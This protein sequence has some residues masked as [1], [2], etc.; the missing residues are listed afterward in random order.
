MAISSTQYIDLLFKSLSGVAKTDLPTN[1]SASNEAIASPILNRGDQ[2]WTESGLIPST[3]AAVS[4]VVQAYTGSSKATAT[5]DSTAQAVGGV[6]PTWRTNLTNWVPPQF[7]TANIT[8]TYRVRIFYGASGLSDPATSGG[9]QI[10]AD[11][12]SGTGEWYFDYASGVLNFIGGTIPAGMTGSSV[13]YVYGYRY[14]GKVGVNNLPAITASGT[15]TFSAINALSGAFTATTVS[16]STTTGALVVN[17]G[18]GIG[19]STF[20]GGNLTVSGTI[21]ATINGVITT[22]TNIAGGTAGQ[23]V[24]Q[25]AP[26]TTTFAGPG[27]AG[28]LLVSN[29]TSGPQYTNTGSIYVGNTVNAEKWLTARTVTFTGD[30]TGT[31]TIDGSADVTSVNLTIQPNS[32]ALGT[33]TTGDYVATGATSGFGLSGSTTGE[34]QTFTVTSNATS[35]NANS[36]I[37]FR[38][39]SGNFSAGTITA[40]TFSGTLGTGGSQSINTNAL[41][42]SNYADN[43]GILYFSNGSGLIASNSASFAW[44]NTAGTLRVKTNTTASSTTTGALVVTGGVG[45]GGQLF[46]GSTA[47]IT[48]TAASTGSVANNALQV[49]GGVGI[50]GSLYVKGPAIFQNDVVFAGTSTYVYSTQTI[51]TD[52]LINM[53]VPSGSTGTDHTW[54]VDDGKDVGF[55][56]HYYKNTD[57]D[58]FLGFNNTS[59]YLEWFNDGNENITNGTFTGTSYGVFKTGGIILTNSTASS[60]PTTGALTVAGGVGIGGN[61]F[62]GGSINGTI[63]TATNLAGGTAGQTPYQTAAG[64]TSFYG[65]GTAGQLLVS[66]GTSGP[67]Y[68]NTGSIYVGNTVNAEKW[69]TARTV[70][71]TGDTTGTFTIDGSANVTNVNLTIQPD[72]VSLGTDTTGNYVATGAT[73]GFGLSGSASSEGGTFTVTSNATATNTPSTI[74][75]RDASG[76]FAAGSITGL[77]T[78]ATNVAGGTAGQ[79]VYQSAAGTTAFA[80]PGTAGQLLVS[81]GTSG[82]Q[83]TNTGS[84]YVS[85]AVN[86][87]KWLTARTVTFTGDTTGTFTIDGSADVT[88]VN[89]SI[90]PNSVA[91]GTD[92]TGDYVAT[93]AVSGFGLSGSTTGESSTFTVNSNATSTNAN[94]TIVFRDS[95]GNFSAGTITAALTGNATSADKWSTARTITLNGDLGGSVTF[96]GSGNATLTATIQANSVDLGSDTTG[97]YVA[98]G[99]TLG[100]GLSGSANSETATFTVSINST[101][102]N[103]TSTVV[104]RDASGNFS[105]DTITAN[106][107]GNATSADKWSTSRTITL[108]GDLGG[109]VTFDGSGNATLTATIQADSIALGTDTTGNYVASGA[110]SGFGLSGSTSTEG[111][112]FNISINSTSSNTASTIVYRDSSGNFSANVVTA[113][114]VGTASSANDLTGGAAGSLPYQSGAGVTVFLPLGLEGKVLIASTSTNAPVWGDIDGGTY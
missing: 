53:H 45:I 1:K 90:Q 50:D 38:D 31:F 25:S 100:F 62:V 30:T 64:V 112:T 107:T 99:A 54:T 101:S 11:G 28:Q 49:L 14:I 71:F 67:Q 108:A 102:S 23:L 73:S 86:A 76:N 75:F 47:T 8:N 36:T 111:G 63:T 97:N 69:L 52:N 3:A 46:V 32:V 13:I 109:S 48:S 82:P 105:A 91:L 40:N 4:G 78:T 72:S 80:G 92:T 81:N 106:L 10:F 57:R 87:E 20:I 21:N 84:I 34:N 9:T 35:T 51:Y 114:L 70:T 17:G 33:D 27:T 6:F 60:S 104:Y 22:A 94:S 19:G 7:D 44:D 95:S 16:V 96:D 15:S 85:N 74:V 59:G 113:D 93:G 42:L 66:N 61:L 56:F 37:V 41:S 88:S 68:T 26:G 83:Y 55:V 77:I 24:Y 18:V 65:P 29:G 12:S 110:T 89:L 103:T 43:T 79:L 39:G 98:S 5:A 2:T 58:A